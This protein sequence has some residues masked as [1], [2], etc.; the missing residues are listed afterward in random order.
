MNQQSVTASAR[1]WANLLSTLGAITVNALANALPLNGQNTGAVSDRFQVY[2]VPAGYVFAIWGVIYLGWLAFSAY[3]LAPSRRGAERFVRLGYWFALSNALNAAW[4]FCWHYGQF[5]LSLAVMVAL[6][7][8]LKMSYARLGVGRARFGAAETLCVDVPFGLY[9]G[10]ISVAT[11]ANASDVFWLWKWDAWGFAPQ[12]WAVVML[13]VGAGLGAWM[14]Y[15]HAEVVFPLVL[16]WAFWGI[17]SRHTGPKALPEAANV[18]LAAQVT[19]AAAVALAT[20]G[21]VRRR[22]LPR[23]GDAIFRG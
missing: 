10:W 20:W 19:A 12:T 16:A 4:L 18:V 13:V 14:V 21:V 3:Q 2:F 8:S 22:T 1:P 15:R 7:V 6:L 17:A 11:I 23:A 9:L 5:G